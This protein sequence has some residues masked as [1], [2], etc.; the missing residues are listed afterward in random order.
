[1][2]SAADHEFMAR[3]LRLA[4]QELWT[5][6][7]NPR[8]GCVLVRDGRIVGEGWHER[9]GEPHA[10]VHALKAAGAAAW[11]APAYVALEPCSHFGRTPPCSVALIEAGVSRVVAAMQDPNPQVAG[12]GFSLLEKAGVAVECGVQ[13]AEARELNVGFVSRMT[14]QRPWVRLKVAG[15][16]DGR[17]ALAD[18]QSQWITGAAARQDGHRWR[19]RACAILTG[20]GTVRDDDPQLTVRGLETP[21]QPLKV[22]VDGRLELSTS[23]R[24]LSGGP[25]LVATASCDAG[26][27]SALIACGAEVLSIPGSDG[28]VDL[29]ALMSALAK[30]GINEVHV[31]GGAGLNGALL[32]AGLVDELLCYVAP[33]LL[34]GDARPLAIL[35]ALGALDERVRFAWHDVRQVGEDLR[36]LVRVV[37]VNV[38]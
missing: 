15:S 12:R 21:R 19:A 8:V 3:A 1:M 36:L 28:R 20:I 5:T 13:E 17:T 24:L 2:A 32:A 6:T 38:A 9:A 25:V 23:A 34:G 10:E 22:I 26:R 14:R 7:P 4:E 11:G 29:P 27:I 33:C 30:Q 37:P 35:P 16:L 31:E 18:G